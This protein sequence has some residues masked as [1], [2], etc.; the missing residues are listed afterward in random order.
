MRNIFETKMKTIR[1]IISL[2]F[3]FI[4]LFNISKTSNKYRDFNN[5]YSNVGY[6]HII[7]QYSKLIHEFQKEKN[8][9][10]TYLYSEGE[11]FKEELVDQVKSTD[12]ALLDYRKV[13]NKYSNLIINLNHL[14]EKIES[15]SIMR[16]RI[17]EMRVDQKKIFEEY[18]EL[19]KYILNNF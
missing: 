9:S 10:Y 7:Q 14:N 13:T 3:S 15:L 4:L 19:I 1:F 5:Q 11:I 18:Q 16:K 2:L 6:I 12:K 8:K 17:L